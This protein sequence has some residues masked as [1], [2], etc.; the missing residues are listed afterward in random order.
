[1]KKKLLFGSLLAVFLMMMLPTAY[2]V[3]SNI[4]KETM[5]S[6]YPIIIPEIDI[7]ELK[8]KYQNGPEPTFI[9][10]LL[11]SIILNLLRIAKFVIPFI[12]ILYIIKKIFGN[13]TTCIIS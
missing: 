11:L 6:Q 7:E 4:V 5:K 12:L 9:L 8:L 10:L 13:N 2:A 3:E 1:M